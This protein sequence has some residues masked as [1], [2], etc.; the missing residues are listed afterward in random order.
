MPYRSKKA[1]QNRAERAK[2]FR[3]KNAHYKESIK[4]TN[5]QLENEEKLRLLTNDRC[6]RFADENNDLGLVVEVLR[7]DNVRLERVADDL[8]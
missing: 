8:T 5:A 3:A 7:G 4:E 6:M 1:Q 2:D